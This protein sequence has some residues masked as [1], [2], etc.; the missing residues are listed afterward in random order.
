[1][2]GFPHTIEPA[3]YGTTGFNHRAV[4]PLAGQVIEAAKS[5]ALSRIVVIGGCGTC[6]SSSC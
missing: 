1:M 2:K 6:W 4:L 5:G 3:T